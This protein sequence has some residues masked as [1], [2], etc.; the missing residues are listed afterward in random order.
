MGETQVR[1]IKMSLEDLVTQ[2]FEE[3]DLHGLR[4]GL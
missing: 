4:L 1:N 2:G 3:L